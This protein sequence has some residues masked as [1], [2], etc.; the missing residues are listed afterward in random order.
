M[1]SVHWFSLGSLALAVGCASAP[2]PAPVLQTV[3]PASD[4]YTH[5]DAADPELSVTRPVNRVD[6][7]SDAWHARLVERFVSREAADTLHFG[8]GGLTLSG[9][10]EFVVAAEQ[11][12]AD[13]RALAERGILLEVSLWE[14]PQDDAPGLDRLHTIAGP[15]AVAVLPSL[16]ALVQAPL[17][18]PSFLV[19][20]SQE[21]K[22]S[23]GETVPLAELEARQDEAGNTT[24]VLEEGAS[25]FAGTSVTACAVLAEEGQ[26]LVCDLEVE[27]SE[28]NEVEAWARVP[29]GVGGLGY[30]SLPTRHAAR[31]SHRVVL[32]RTE[33]AWLVTADP[34][35][36][37]G[38]LLVALRWETVDVGS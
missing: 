3:A 17:Q 38:L 12:L 16:P 14:L 24:V 25:T 10:P 30:Q 37:G 2:P 7:R 29:V 35:T 18:A 21:A 36:D 4:P 15:A 32:R 22:I 23:V 27:R 11:F 31:V 9:S 34:R 20:D 28:V 13:R 6:D 33:V 26:L 1:R 5:G 19:L 8:L